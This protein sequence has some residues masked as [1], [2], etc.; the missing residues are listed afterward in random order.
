MPLRQSIQRPIDHAWRLQYDT[1]L[2]CHA[3]AC[4]VQERAGEV[5]AR[6]VAAGGLHGLLLLLQHEAVGVHHSKLAASMVTLMNLTLQHV[7]WAQVTCRGRGGG[8]C[9]VWPPVVPLCDVSPSCVNV[10]VG[11]CG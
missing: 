9:I 7:T 3:C 4:A 6:F 8:C 10:V 11:G 2:I 1:A 5:T